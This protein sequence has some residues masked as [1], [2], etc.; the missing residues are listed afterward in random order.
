MYMN[1]RLYFKSQMY[2]LFIIKQTVYID[3]VTKINVF[4]IINQLNKNINFTHD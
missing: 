4:V 1:K 3:Y 2:Y